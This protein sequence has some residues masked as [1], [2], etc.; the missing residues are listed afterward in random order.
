MSERIDNFS[1][2][3]DQVGYADEI[4]TLEDQYLRLKAVDGVDGTFYQL[5]TKTPWSFSSVEDIEILIKRFVRLRDS[6]G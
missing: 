1:M 6:L 5:E 2:L 4:G 3:H